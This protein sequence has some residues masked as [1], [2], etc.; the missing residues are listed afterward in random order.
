[1]ST[2]AEPAGTLEVAMAHA[3]RLLETQPLLA[4]EQAQAILEAV[5]NHPPAVLLLARGHRLTGDIAAALAVIEPLA[6]RQTIWAAAHFELGLTLARAGRGDEAIQAL[7]NTVELKPQHPLA[8]RHLADHLL[9]TGNAEAGDA[10]YVRHIQCSTRDPLMQQSAA[11]MIDN[12]IPKAERLLKAHLQQAPTDVPAIRML[13][14]VAVRCGRN[15]E[16]ENLLLRALELAPSFNSARYNYA[17]LLHRRNDPAQALVEIERLLAAD[18]ASPSYR[19]LCAVILSRIGEYRRSGE[20]YAQLLAEYPATAKVWLSYGHVLKTEGR[21]DECIDAYRQSIVHN[22]A[23]GEA[24]W[25]LANL[26]TFR[27][28]H[29]DSAQMNKQLADSSLDD[30][31]RLHLHFALGK[32]CE[33]AEDHAGA[34]T[35]YDQGN[36]LHR[37]NHPYDANLNTTRTARLKNSF[38]RDFFRERTGTGCNS[39][40]PIFIVGMPR[41]GSTLLEQILSSHSAV[42]GTTE[43]PDIISMAKD[44]RDEAD[45]D[46][47]VAYTGV[48]AD[49]NA[50]ELLELGEQYLE[51]TRVHRK[52]D[53]PF[54]I[55][56]MPNNFLHIGMIQLVL[57]NAKI[58]DARRHPMGCCFSN[59]KQY[60]ARGQNFSY[61]LTDMGRFY[62]DYV[63]LMA[64]YDEVLPGRV[65]RVFY[66]QT[67]ADTETEIRKLLDYCGLKF[68]PACLRF[69]ENQRP[70]RT[71]SSEQVRQP[72]YQ[73]GVE[74]WRLYEEWLDPLKESLGEVLMSYPVA[75]EY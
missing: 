40:A 2:E 50:A 13:A 58:I 49:K 51:R 9:A 73:E 46:E 52:T 55:D 41:A 47:I 35:H 44:L 36:T 74:Q 22:P 42:E 43:L 53:R 66:E 21:I 72:I 45:S 31:S 61:G 37:A 3:T 75:P 32:A 8:W 62:R 68:E 1:M 24:Y 26:K 17:V 14:E 60:Y 30:E 64:H 6:A 7:R 23:F 65:H 12:D 57:P 39:S 67:V 34:F 5:P 59:F 71:A 48:L 11:A 15:E 70:V 19:N 27:F 28:T 69:F 29:A 33:D 4:L 18:A 56:K 38:S 25:S 20:M 54:F 16:A 10:A 63:E